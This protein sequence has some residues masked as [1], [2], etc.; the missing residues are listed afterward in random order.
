MIAQHGNSVEVE[1]KK[2]RVV[3]NEDRILNRLAAEIRG[4]VDENVE[5][6]DVER[7]M[8]LSP[9]SRRQTERRFR[10]RF[11]TSPARYFRDC[12]WVCAR[13]L[14]K[15][16]N[17]VLSASTKS[18]FASPGRLH[19]AVLARSGLTPGEMRRGG[20]GVHIDFGFFRTQIGIV[21]IA[22]TKRGLSSL[23]LCGA[24]PSADRMAEEVDEFF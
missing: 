4:Q 3:I 20:A 11:L 5:R 16:G 13:R 24:S 10:D 9:W 19:D 23:R 1:G 8:A 17:D 7:L 15:E 14:L 21:L 12:Q 6:F 22:A 2:G 18:G